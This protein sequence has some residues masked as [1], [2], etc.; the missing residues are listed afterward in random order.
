MRKI[1]FL[2]FF[3]LL[4]FPTVN[5]QGFKAWVEGP[6]YYTIGRHELVNIYVKNLE[7]N[8]ENYSIITYKKA[9]KPSG[10][11]C[12]NSRVDHLL[13]VSLKSSKISLV[14]Q[15]QTRSTFAIVTLLGPVCNGEITFNVSSSSESKNVTLNLKGGGYP[16]NLSEFNVLLFSLF[17]ILSSI[18]LFP[19]KKES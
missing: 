9:F 15:N 4:L 2:T 14:E 8:L 5:A 1:L 7:P 18:F 13:D 16:L 3:L 11:T 6:S 17:L 10:E 19:H 12:T